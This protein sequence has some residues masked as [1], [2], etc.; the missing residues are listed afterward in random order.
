[1]APALPLTPVIHTIEVTPTAYVN[2]TPVWLMYR[3]LDTGAWGNEDNHRDDRVPRGHENGIRCRYCP[4]ESR[5]IA[6]HPHRL[7]LTWEDTED[8]R[9]RLKWLV[10]PE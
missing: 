10:V 2:L 8:G 6:T 1:M 9:G 3:N 5:V 4:V 7:R